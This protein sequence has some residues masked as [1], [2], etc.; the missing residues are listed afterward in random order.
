MGIA[1]TMIVLIAVIRSVPNSVITNVLAD[2]YCV[3]V[4]EW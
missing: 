4:G 2:V 1:V 3:E